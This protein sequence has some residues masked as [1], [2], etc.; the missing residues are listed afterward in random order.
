MKMEEGAGGGVC[1]DRLIKIL[2][3][4]HMWQTKP[5]SCSACTSPVSHSFFS[6]SMYT[7]GLDIG[8]MLMPLKKKI[9]LP[10]PRSDRHRQI[11]RA[12][13]GCGRSA[14]VPLHAIRERVTQTQI[15][16][17]RGCLCGC[18]V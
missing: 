16:V 1:L 17:L 5:W 6:L 11:C 4:D 10:R 15:V 13:R 18:G 14:R 12:R 8:P 3:K 7:C 9:A 2:C